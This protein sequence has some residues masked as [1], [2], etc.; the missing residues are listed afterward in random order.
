MGTPEF[1]VSCLKRII[2]DGHEV[3][4]VL[5]QADKPKGRGYTLTPPPVKAY[6]L[7]HGIE[8]YQ[9]EKLK[10]NSEARAKIAGCKADA[11]VVVAFGQILPPE[12]LAIPKCGCINVHASLLPKYRGAAPIQWSVING[13]KETGV[14]TMLMDSGLDTGDMLIKR[15]VEITPDM[16]AGE[17]HDLLAAEGSVALSDTLKAMEKGALRPEKQDDSLSCYAGMLSRDLSP[18]DWKKPAGEVHN[19]IRGLNPWPSACTAVGGKTLKVH[20]SRPLSGGGASPGTVINTSPLTIACGDHTSIELVEVQL[21]GTK[22]MSS[23][24]YLRGHP[25]KKGRILPD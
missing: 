15:S 11:A 2:E 6:A 7:T 8:V 17:L 18:I 1:A 4:L 21:E 12:V 22:R 23:D 16:T 25:L 19:L 20:R 24:E 3:V 5:T 14:T 10:N 13:E 9:P